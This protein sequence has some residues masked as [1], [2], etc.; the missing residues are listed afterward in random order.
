MRKR[1]KTTV[2]IMEEKKKQMRE[3]MSQ[4]GLHSLNHR[5]MRYRLRRS[6][7]EFLSIVNWWKWMSKLVVMAEKRKY[8]RTERVLRIEMEKENE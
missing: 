6:I 5:R 3:I 1:K 7:G 4:R 2:K 8:D